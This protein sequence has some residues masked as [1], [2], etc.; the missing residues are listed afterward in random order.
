MY[1]FDDLIL[2]LQ[3]IKFVT[4]FS[5]KKCFAFLFWNYEVIT[6]WQYLWSFSSPQAFAFIASGTI[7]RRKH[8]QVSRDS[9][10]FFSFLRVVRLLNSVYKPLALASGFLGPKLKATNL[11][12]IPPLIFALVGK[13]RTYK[14]GVYRFSKSTFPWPTLGL[15]LFLVG[16]EYIRC[17]AI[18]LKNNIQYRILETIGH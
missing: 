2:H 3:K 16:Y 4:F 10:I 15:N 13:K 6:F 1:L 14:K 5:G 18:D 11:F 7:L 17:S 8:L 9:C 12:Q